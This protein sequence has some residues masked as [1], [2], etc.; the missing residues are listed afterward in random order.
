MSALRKSVEREPRDFVKLVRLAIANLFSVNADL[1]IKRYPVCRFSVVYT[2][3]VSIT[4]KF[5]IKNIR[6]IFLFYFLAD[7]LVNGLAEFQ[8]TAAY[9]PSSM[10]VPGVIVT[11]RHNEFTL[12][13]MT[14]IHD[15][16]ANVIYSFH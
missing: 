10:F 12:S 15:A 1:E 9:V 6:T 11:F 7:C 14:K 2:M 4:E 5:I 3:N 8:P 13:V 16:H